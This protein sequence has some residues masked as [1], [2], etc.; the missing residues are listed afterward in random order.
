MFT[1]STL[2]MGLQFS[3]LWIARSLLQYFKIIIEWRIFR[4]IRFPRRWWRKHHLKG[5]KKSCQYFISRGSINKSIPQQLKLKAH[6]SRP[7]HSKSSLVNPSAHG[8]RSEL[9]WTNLNEN[10]AVFKPIAGQGWWRLWWVSAKSSDR[11]RSV[12]I[13]NQ[14]KIEILSKLSWKI[15]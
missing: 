1:C 8:G 14:K 13:R 3:L 2:L 11:E 4:D 15:A 10:I 7:P 6:T 5:L 12:A 9:G